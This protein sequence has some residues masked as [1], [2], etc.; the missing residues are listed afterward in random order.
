[1]HNCKHQ[2]CKHEKVK[3][4]EICKKVYCEGCGMEWPE[5]NIEFYPL[6]SL[7]PTV[8]PWFWQEI[9]TTPNLNPI[10]TY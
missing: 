9:I 10:V 7:Y 8:N 5:K 1:M 2:E 3:F 4:C 6:Y